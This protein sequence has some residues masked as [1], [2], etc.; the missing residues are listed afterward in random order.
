MRSRR[1][2]R[3]LRFLSPSLPLP[4]S[5]LPPRGRRYPP[6]AGCSPTGRRLPSPG[7][8]EG[9]NRSPPARLPHAPAA[10]Q[11]PSAGQPGPRTGRGQRPPQPRA[12]AGPPHGTQR[13]HR[14][15][16]CTADGGSQAWGADCGA[17]VRPSNKNVPTT[18][19]I[20]I[21]A[22]LN[23]KLPSTTKGEKQRSSFLRKENPEGH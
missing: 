4:G 19:Y 22:S 9:P 7:P 20:N 15:K 18:T 12:A 8:C 14:P 1:E 10:A 16:Q 17:R 3:R 2:R 11:R 6:R 13:R 23:L 21:S 5:C